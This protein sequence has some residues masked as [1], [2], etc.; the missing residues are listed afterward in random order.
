M[1]QFKSIKSQ[2]IGGI[3]AII[4]LVMGAAAYFIINQE[5]QEVNFDIF[6]NAVNFAELTNER[7]VDNYE[8]N[9]VEQAYVNFERDLADIYNLNED[10]SSMVIY[11]FS[12]ELLYQPNGLNFSRARNEKLDRIQSI[13]P[14]VITKTGRVVYLDK[15]DGQLRYTDLNGAPV[16]PV[17]KSEQI[18]NIIFPFRDQSDS[19]RA[20]SLQYNV[21]YEALDDRIRETRMNLLI[22]AVFSIL[23]A[24][25]VGGVIADRITRPIKQLTVGVAKI[26]S[27]DLKTRIDVQTKSEIGQLA[28]TFNQMASDL[29][30]GTELLV[31]KEKIT[32]ELELAGEIQR[33]LLPKEIPQIEKLDIAASLISA[34]EVGGDGY[35]FLKVNDDNWIFYV[36]DVTGHGVPAGLVSAINNALVPAF[37][38]Y[39]QDTKELVIYLNKILKDKT[40]SSVFLTMMMAHWNVQNA[41]LTYTPAGHNPII[42]YEAATGMVKELATGGMALGMIPDISHVV[43]AFQVN[44]QVGDVAVL[45]TDGIPEAWKNPEEAYGMERFKN[46]LAKSRNLASAQAIHDTIY[47]DLKAFT[48]NYP[49]ADDIT[50]VVI[51]RSA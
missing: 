8:L 24:L 44:M 43:S 18:Q 31:Q 46:S 26:G 5:I 4:I 25:F 12:G 28:N 40:K 7:V 33:E 49:Q 19:L 38:N 27:G 16:E 6:N 23:S 45:Y 48:G 51:K 15:D 1:F 36:G 14:S 29:E 20:Y 50:L 39:S 35:D 30:K 11:N 41:V 22:L 13:I 2:I 37:L 17:E 21:S 34:D 3:S 32:R 47:T 10:I 9:Y 42:Y